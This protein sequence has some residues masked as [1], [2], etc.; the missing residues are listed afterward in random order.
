M[1]GLLAI[2]TCLPPVEGGSS[3]DRAVGSFR[4]LTIVCNM[5]IGVPAICNVPIGV[6]AIYE[7]IRVRVRAS[8]YD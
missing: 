8:V 7:A 3:S 2:L 4:H 1:I 5:A 6:P